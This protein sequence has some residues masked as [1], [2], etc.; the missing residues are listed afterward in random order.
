MHAM[1]ALAASHITAGEA[2]ESADL[3]CSAM[4]H[5]VKSIKALNATLSKG[6]KSLEEGNAM[7]ATCYTLL[8]Q[9]LYVEDGMLEFMSFTRGCGV[10]AKTMGYGGFGFLFDNFPDEENP[11]EKMRPY[12]DG[13]PG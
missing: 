7:L 8:F 1:L 9:S 10:V 6:I 13:P 4:S 5:R 2:R 11:H 3:V 12:L